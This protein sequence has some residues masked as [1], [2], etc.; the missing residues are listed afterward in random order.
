MPATKKANIKAFF[1]DIEHEFMNRAQVL[2]TRQVYPIAAKVTA[3]AEEVMK[4]YGVSSMTG[5]YINSFGVAV[6]RDSRLVAIATSSDVTGESPLRVTLVEGEWYAKGKPRY[7]G[8]EQKRSWRA[9]EG[10]HAFFADDEVVRWLNRYPPTR[11]K[12]FSYRV[13]TVVDYA[14][15][16]GGDVVLMRLADELESLNGELRS[17]RF[18]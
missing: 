16:L 4:R 6:Y 9:A 15:T 8:G 3:Y 7:D 13:V 11:K 5:N 1:K 17:F 18:A 14:K 2:A 12:G 10:S